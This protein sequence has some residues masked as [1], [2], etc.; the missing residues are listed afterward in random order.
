MDILIQEKC[1]KSLKGKHAPRSPDG[2]S[3]TEQE[4]DTVADWPSS[5]MSKLTLAELLN[6]ETAAVGASDDNADG[7]D[8]D[9]SDI[10]SDT[11]SAANLDAGVSTRLCDMTDESVRLIPT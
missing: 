3:V 4:L 9:L 2:Y 11:E 6:L 10:D 5:T 8:S 7:V 1:E